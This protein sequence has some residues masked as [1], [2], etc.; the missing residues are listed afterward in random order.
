MLHNSSIALCVL[1]FFGRFGQAKRVARVGATSVCAVISPDLPGFCSCDTKKALGGTLTCSAKLL[2]A[3]A[4]CGTASAYVAPAAPKAVGALNS[5]AELEALAEGN[6]DFLGST[7]GFWDPLGISDQDFWNLGNEG[8]IGYLRHAEIKHGR[9]AMAGFLGFL[10]QCTPIVSGEHALPPYRGYVAGVTPQEQWDNIPLIGKLQIFTFVGMLES[11]GEGAGQPDGYVHYTK[12][13]LPGY[14]PPIEG[15]IGPFPIGNLNLYKPF[16]IFPEQSED[17]KARGRQVEINN[18]RLAMLGLISLL[19]ES[20]GLIVPPSTASRASQART[21][22]SAIGGAAARPSRARDRARRVRHRRPRRRDAG[23]EG[24]G[25]AR[26]PLSGAR[27]RC[28]DGFAPGE[29]HL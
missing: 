7:L 2:V 23:R 5:K 21:F 19:T 17:E 6:G 22:A 3:L 12:G 4:L 18:G 29:A 25:S 26:G 27:S 24:G 8:T 11:Y 1:G 16:D 14:F 15:R 9:V 20:N 28:P 10:A 13:G